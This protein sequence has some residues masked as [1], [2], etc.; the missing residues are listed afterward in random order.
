MIQRIQKKTIS[1]GISKDKLYNEYDRKLKIPYP[2]KENYDSVIPLNIYQTWHTKNLP[3]KMFE[4]INLIKNLNPRFNYQL[5][6][7]N[8]CREFIKNNFEPNVLHAFNS[9]IPGAYKAD[10]WRYCVLYKNGGIY[11]DIKY[12]PLNNFR[13]ITMTEKEH[14]VLDSDKNGVY[15]ALMICKPGNEILLKAINKIIENVKNKYYGNN[16]LQPTGPQLLAT[17]FSIN[18]KN[19]FDMKHSFYGSHE[20]RFI[21]FKSYLIF[22]SYS[23]YL[24]EHSNNKKISHYHDLWIN[25][26]IYNN[27]C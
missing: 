22:K 23:G 25:K 4:T 17:F 21:H 9:L 27:I 18:E 5:F 11:L 3:P 8:D 19:K 2:L 13:F 10:L 24:N 1:K 6:D 20:N 15:N 16:A 26:S 14:W 12:R 7:D